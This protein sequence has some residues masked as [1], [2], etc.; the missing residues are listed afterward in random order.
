MGRRTSET[1]KVRA[2]RG[3]GFL[4]GWLAK[5]RTR[6]ANRLIPDRLRDGCILDIGCGTH[7]TFL[8]ATRFREK[9]SLDQL[10]MAPETAAALGIRHKTH[11]LAA[12]PCLPFPDDAFAVV[13]LLAV[14]E[15]LE[16]AVACQVLREA[17][18][19]LA[20]GGRVIVT[21]PAAW[22]DKLLLLLAKLH[23]VSPE[24]IHEHTFAYRP[25]TLGCTLGQAG[26]HPEKL[27]CG[28][29]ELGMNLWAMAEKEA[30]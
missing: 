25:A 21:T 1:P 3:D 9:C 30:G 18:R 6:Q 29:F 17:H 24:E 22:A 15:H 26:F 11:N 4:E 19:V 5:Q 14:I 23:I 2:T 12:N 16:L 8:A 20:P 27:R 7:P 28:S 13:T 10:A